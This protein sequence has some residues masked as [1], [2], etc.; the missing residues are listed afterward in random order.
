MAN[1][2]PPKGGM[3]ARSLQRP[4]DARSQL[5]VLAVIRVGK[6][7]RD[8]AVGDRFLPWGGSNTVHCQLATKTA[9]LMLDARRKAG[10]T[11]R[12]MKERGEL[13]ER[14]GRN[15]SQPGTHSLDD[16]GLTKNQSS[17]YQQEASV[18]DEVYRDWVAAIVESDAREL[19]A[20]GHPIG[21]TSHAQRAEFKTNAN[22]MILVARQKQRH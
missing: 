21:H 13:A 15:G 11:I 7:A 5:L 19:T 18:P 8:E 10:E 22:P 6:L 16:L 20:A 17:R 2:F 9:R 4:Q 14:V 3:V 1:D 12:L